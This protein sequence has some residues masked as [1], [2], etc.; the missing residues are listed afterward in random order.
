MINI[1]PNCKGTF[2]E[3]IGKRRRFSEMTQQHKQK[4]SVAFLGKM[5]WT[6][7][8]QE[9]PLDNQEKYPSKNNWCS[10]KRKIG[11]SKLR[12]YEYILFLLQFN[13]QLEN[14]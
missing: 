8:S 4:N 2:P 11:K 13:L 5:E 14:V 12:F 3:R 10:P 6:F 7:S 9:L 1:S